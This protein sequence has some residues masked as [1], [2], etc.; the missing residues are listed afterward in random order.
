MKIYGCNNEL[1]K[2]VKRT[3]Q[4]NKKESYKVL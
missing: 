1:F 3:K 2:N 4:D